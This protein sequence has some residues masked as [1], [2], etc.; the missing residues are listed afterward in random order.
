M[1][2]EQFNYHLPQ[3]LIAQTPLKKRSSSK[4][5]TLGRRSGEI[6]HRNF[7][8]ITQYFQ[9]GDCLVLNNSKVI[10]VRL[11]GLRKHTG[12]NIE[13]LLL[14][15]TDEKD[16]WLALVKPAR[17]VRVGDGIVFGQDQLIATCIEEREDGIRL[18]KLSYSGILLEVL[19]ELGDMPLPPYIKEKLADDDRYQ[20]VYA[21]VH[22][23]SAAP[24]AGLHFTHSLLRE[25][26]DMGVHIVYVTLHVG[27]GTFRPV[28]TKDYTKHRMHAEYYDLSE[29]NARILREAKANGRQIF[30]VGTTVARVL[31]TVTRGKDR[32]IKAESGWTDIYIYPPYDFQAVDGLITNFH[33]PKSSL[34]LLVS[35]FATKDYI[36]KA[37]AEAIEQEYRFF[38]FGDAMFVYPEKL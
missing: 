9:K 26:K 6:S 32:R 13:I 18:F 23:S 5:L 22:G 16:Y 17:K 28:V 27:L 14:H 1:N 20:T 7:T 24:T 38:S 34:L 3:H 10:P 36:L 12:A 19:K 21:E 25:L 35:A 2:I 30:A 29:K 37:Y 4:L 11:F 15:E 31:E 8:E 33:L